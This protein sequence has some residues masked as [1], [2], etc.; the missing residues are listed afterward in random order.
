MRLPLIILLLFSSLVL[1]GQDEPAPRRGVFLEIAGSG[2]LGSLN[3]ESIFFQRDLIDLSFR[4]GLSIAPIDRNNGTGLVFPVML[5]ALIGRQHHRLEAGIGQGITITTR[6][7]FYLLTTMALGYRFQRRDSPWFYR[8]TYTPL[9]SYLLD[10][11]YQHW[12]GISV[13]YTLPNQ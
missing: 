3:Y 13:G 4:S 2:G 7:S 10:V 11:Q 8:V 1:L 6:G 12:A 9:L 5:N